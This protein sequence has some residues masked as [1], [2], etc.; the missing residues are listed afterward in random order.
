MTDRFWG[1]AFVSIVL[2][3]SCTPLGCS[4]GPAEGKNET[5]QPTETP[6]RTETPPPAVEKIAA[7]EFSAVEK[8]VHAYMESLGDKYESRFGT[9]KGEALLLIATSKE[10]KKPI[11]EVA[12]IYRLIENSR[13]G[14]HL[15]DAEVDDVG[16]AHAAACAQ[17]RAAEEEVRERPGPPG[18]GDDGAV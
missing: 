1:T 3:M 17:A 2:A 10:F 6:P 9:E 14:G 11:I 4:K 8:Q 12:R 5:P 13:L 7:R 15:S 16:Q 18:A